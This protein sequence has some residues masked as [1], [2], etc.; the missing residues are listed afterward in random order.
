MNPKKKMWFTILGLAAGILV[1][2]YIQ[3]VISGDNIYD[4]LGK[5]KDVLLTVQK[6]YV[7]DVDTPKLVESAITGMLSELDPHSVYIPAEQQKRVEEDFRGSFQGIGVEFDV[8]RDTI[9]VVSP[10]SGGP[11]EQLGIHA[12]DKI[13]KIDGQNAV[14]MSRDDVPKKLRGP[15]GTHVVVTVVRYGTADPLVFDITRDNIPLYT[16]DAAF[17]NPDGTGYLA[18]NRF[19]EPTYDEMMKNL[20]M[21]SKQGMKRLILD[22]R[23][24]PGGYME[25]A[26]RIVDEFVPGGHKIVYT[27]STRNSMEDVYMSEDGQHYEKL[28]LIVLLNAGSAS[29]SEI[30]AGAIQDLDRGLIVGET[31]FGKGLVQKQF[32]LQDGS[33]FRLTV[34]RYYTP[35]GRLIQRPYDKGKED[36]YKM[37]NRQE[38]EEGD[39]LDHTHDVADSSRPVFKTTGGRKVLGG[40]GVT[41][42]YVIKLDTVT[43]LTI[44]LIR[45]NLIWEYTERFTSSADGQK[46]RSQYADKFMDFLKNYDISEAMLSDF[47]KYAKDKGVEV[48]PDQLAA[49]REHIKTR[50]KA[51][52]AR[53]FWGNSEFYQVALQDDKQYEKALTLFPEANRVAKLGR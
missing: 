35:S 6:N 44:D 36:Y 2:I 31:S 40:G 13:V 47:M 34:A 9:T 46:V 37:T 28:P 16:V 5:F 8:V 19:A 48:K 42:D 49:D 43:P 14:G 20:D 23:G 26:I 53:T 32:P 24:N 30:V 3:P 7:D 50:L 25:K 27:K 15:K 1:G 41:P 33:A 29:A 4:Q 11:S 18:L 10:I 12:G 17:V 21:L 22:L 51:R 39:N 38:D 52:I 45:K